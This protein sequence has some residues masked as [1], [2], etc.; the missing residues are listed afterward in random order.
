M[1]T[2][3]TYVI[4]AIAMLVLVAGLWFV[5]TVDKQRAVDEASYEAERA[6]QQKI[7][8]DLS[9]Q[10]AARNA[11][12]KEKD[13]ALQA[14][15]DAAKSVQQQLSL[16]EKRM[17]LPQP[18][19]VNVPA[20]PG[21]PA[22]MQVNP[23]AEQ[24]VKPALDYTTSCEQCKIDLDA[25]RANEADKD[26]QIAAVSAERDAAVTMANG[27]SFWKRVKRGAKWLAIGGAVAGGAICGTGHCK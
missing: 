1:T 16:I 5:H 20:Q 11:E 24:D 18:I 26:K 21:Q 9:A 25:A 23:Q 6:Q 12:A 15:A 8:A 22:A 19:T 14:Q 7:V 13:A 10:I 27:G 2:Q 17:N 4:A 3:K